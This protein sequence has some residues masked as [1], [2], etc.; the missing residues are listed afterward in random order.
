VNQYY[1]A[2]AAEYDRRWGR[3]G[4]LADEVRFLHGLA[5]A[6]PALEVGIGT[7]RVAV[8][9]AEAG[10]RVV[11]VDPSP[12]MLAVLEQKLRDHPHLPVEARLG[13]MGLSGVAGSFSLIYCVYHT[14]F[15]A[16]SRVEQQSFFERAAELLAAG[17]AVVVE[18]Y[19]PHGGRRA[20]WAKG[21]HV[22]DVSAQGF[23]YEFYRHDEHEQTLYIGSA[24]YADG[25]MR[26][27]YWEE[28]Y[29]T[30]G[31][32]DDLAEKA[33][34]AL[35]ERWG[36]FARQP[37]EPSGRRCVSVYHHRD[38]VRDSGPQPS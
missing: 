6:G 20:R 9:L 28:R 37:F 31:Q 17:G 16:D 13:S 24:A 23:E 5:G 29:L 11:G 30:P 8:P 19:S 1:D 21:V 26:Y 35:R 27:A 12:G 4:T 15:Y 33:G 18:G 7:G 14:L 25:T 3:P 38:A 32:I 22:S 34:L 10:V 2:V 36:G